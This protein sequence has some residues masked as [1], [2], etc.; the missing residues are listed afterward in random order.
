MD[1]HHSRSWCS[2]FQGSVDVKQQRFASTPAVDNTAFHVN[3][4]L[5]Q[6]DIVLLPDLDPNTCVVALP[7]SAADLNEGPAPGDAFGGF[8]SALKS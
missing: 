2:R 7:I 1:E 3:A 4:F 6:G 5:A 8:A